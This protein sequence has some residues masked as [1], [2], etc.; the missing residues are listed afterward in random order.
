MEDINMTQTLQQTINIVEQLDEAS[1]IS[2]LNF[3]RFLAAENDNALYDNAKEN[4]D[5]YRVSSQDLRAK[6]GI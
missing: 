2:V 1:Q 4:D 5:G 3:A 6:Y